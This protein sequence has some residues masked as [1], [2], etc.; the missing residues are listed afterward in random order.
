[1]QQFVAG[2]FGDRGSLVLQLHMNA[3][4]QA[5]LLN[6]SPEEGAGI[7]STVPGSQSLRF[8]IFQMVPWYFRLLFHT[9]R[10]HVDD[11]VRLPI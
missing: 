4:A 1:M 11:Q 10:L 9:M 2:R 5:G 3:V 8:C 6:D 7:N